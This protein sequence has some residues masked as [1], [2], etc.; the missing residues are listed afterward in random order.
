MAALGM[1]TVCCLS[2]LA[3]EVS[4]HS[5]QQ[6]RQC[7]MSRVRSLEQHLSSKDRELSRVFASKEQKKRQIQ[8]L[9][10]KVQHLKQTRLQAR[11]KVEQLEEQLRNQ[12]GT[13]SSCQGRY[14]RMES[15]EQRLQDKSRELSMVMASKQRK[16]DQISTL[17]SMVQHLKKTRSQARTTVE[18]L[19]ALLELGRSSS[20]S[21]SPTVLFHKKLW[22]VAIALAVLVGYLLGLL[23]SPFNGRLKAQL[24]GRTAEESVQTHAKEGGDVA[25]ADESADEAVRK[26]AT[27]SG[28]SAP[29]PS[30][31]VSEVAR[32][33]VVDESSDGALHEA[34]T[35]V[36]KSTPLPSEDVSE[37]TA[38]C[39]SL[40]ALVILGAPLH[41]ATQDEP[42]PSIAQDESATSIDGEVCLPETASSECTSDEFE[43]M[44]VVDL[45][46]E[47][48]EF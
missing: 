35:E 43:I 46:P 38:Q 6:A 32:S 18:E 44:E 33:Y 16:K 42:A 13:Q 20:R 11:Q 24:E 1:M 28:K 47:E 29:L 22:L 9:E 7:D 10:S 2:L 15:L 4:S 12:A 40:D 37:V 31:D 21:S 48:P 25:V 41:D 5:Y 26:A 45:M 36:E 17:Q 34:T 30:E 39:E 3:L 23:L 8:S 19:R 27:E 14:Q